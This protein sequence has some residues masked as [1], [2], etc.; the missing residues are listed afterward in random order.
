M[1]FS[2][3]VSKYELRLKIIMFLFTIYKYVYYVKREVKCINVCKY[4]ITF[5]KKRIEYARRY[6]HDR[7]II[8]KPQIKISII[9]LIRNK[10][11]MLQC[12]KKKFARSEIKYKANG[13]H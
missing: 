4:H 5:V 9:F 12:N 8:I 1:E 10:I 7:S 11:Q 3:V 13:L 6:K 2:F